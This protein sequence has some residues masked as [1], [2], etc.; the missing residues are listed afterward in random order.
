MKHS[1]FALE[2]SEWEKG[3]EGGCKWQAK[4]ESGDP[5]WQPEPSSCSGGRSLSL[6]ALKGQCL[7][8]VFHIRPTTH[9]CIKILAIAIEVYYYF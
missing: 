9:L 8:L 5:G 1:G 4:E 2:K 3:L 6:E 7:C